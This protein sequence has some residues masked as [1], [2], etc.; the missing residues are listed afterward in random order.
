M[1][2]IFFFPLITAITAAVG[3]AGY[4]TFSSRQFG[5]RRM[6]ISRSGSA[7]VEKSN[8]PSTPPAACSPCRACR[9]APSSPGRCKTFS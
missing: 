7:S 5:R 6:Q 3:A 8:S 1:K 2:R 9:S 4:C